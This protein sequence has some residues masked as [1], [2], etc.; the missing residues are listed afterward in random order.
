MF[1][2]LLVRKMIQKRERFLGNKLFQKNTICQYCA[3]R[4]MVVYKTGQLSRAYRQ[5]GDS[6]SK[7]I[8]CKEKGEEE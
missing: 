2:A 1:L 8:I 7:T 4:M 6:I 3:G 5:P